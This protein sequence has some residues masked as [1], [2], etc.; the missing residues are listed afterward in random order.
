VTGLP[1]SEPDS[2]WGGPRTILGLVLVGAAAL[3]LIG[4]QYGLPYGGLLNPDEQNIVPRA[5]AIVHGAGVDPHPF[6]DYPS[7]LLYVLAPFEAWHTHPSYLAARL[8]AVAIG[9]GGVAAAWWLGERAYGVMAGGV[10][11][12]TVAVAT[13]HVAYS[14]MAVTDVLLTTLVTVALALLV[15]DRIEL[16]GLVAG[17]AAAAKYPGALLLVPIAIVAWGRWRR[18]V[19]AGALLLGGFALGTPFVLAHPGEAWDDFTRV[20]GRARDGWLG[21]EHDH[22][23]PIAFADRLWESLGPIVV[24]AV[25]GLA[26]ALARRDRADRVLASWT[27]VYFVSLL[28][29]GA[30]FDRYVLPLIPALAVLAA[31][32]VA[33]APVLVL[34]LVVPLTWTIEHDRELMKTD[35]RAAAVP[36]IASV[37]DGDLVAVDP[38]VPEPDR[39]R[40][41]RLGLPAP[42]QDPDPNRDVLR[43]VRRGARYV[44]VTGAIEDRVRAAPKE[45]PI[46]NR[47]LDQLERSRPVLRVDPD[48]ELGGPWVA[49]Y[50]LARVSLGP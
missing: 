31:R 26:V 7:L 24:V 47:F 39:A 8:A 1:K 36:R 28:P 2:R 34:L 38:S 33:L 41:I 45:Y 48:G 22:A 19:G 30:H 15:T 37:V 20:N 17:L 43:L 23:S 49:L 29:I 14:R 25:V 35:A 4:V 27:L 3:R 46:E 21:F 9:V 6:F 12:V 11:A 50:R 10:A 18:L 42:W 13:V 5:W 16:A 44:V 32:F 40:V